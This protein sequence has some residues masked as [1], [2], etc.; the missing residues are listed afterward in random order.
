MDVGDRQ[1]QESQQ[2]P[3]PLATKLMRAIVISRWSMVLGLWLT[4]GS[5]AIWS[6]R[7]EFVL[8]RDYLTWASL[9]YGL[10]YNPWAALALV[11]CIAYTCA[12]GVWHSQKL[13]SGWSPR[14]L[15]RLERQAT[16]I[17][18]NPRHWLWQVLKKI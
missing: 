18:Q 15:Y 8:W 1:K 17:S 13:L 6:L 5:F 2:P 4:L 11:L 16:K 12:V 10:A 3:S 9:R 7:S 14:E